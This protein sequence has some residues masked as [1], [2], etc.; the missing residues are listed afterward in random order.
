VN[1]YRGEIAIIRPD[2]SDRRTLSVDP[3][4]S[5]IEELAW[6]TLPNPTTG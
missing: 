3:G 1:G 4:I 2:G 6:G 5:T